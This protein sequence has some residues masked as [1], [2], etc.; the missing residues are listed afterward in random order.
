[1]SKRM[2]VAAAFAASVLIAARC[3]RAEAPGWAM[4]L[5]GPV[6]GSAVIHGE[7]A[8]FGR[9]KFAAGPEAKGA[10]AKVTPVEGMTS[11]QLYKAE[12]KTPFAVFSVY[13]KFFAENGY[14]TV[15][16]CEAKAC[17]QGFKDAWYGLN[18]F[19]EDYGWNNSAPLTKGAPETQFYI[20]AKKANPAG[21]VYVSVYV[22]SGWWNYPVY[23]L[24][25]AKEAPLGAG[26][27]K[28]EKIAEAMKRE[29]RIAFYGI[30]FDSGSSAI[31]PES[32]PVLDQIAAFLKASPGEKFYVVGH[33]DDEGDLQANMKLS[34][35]RAQAVLKD[36]Q[37]RGV[38]A[39]AL[40][41]HGAGPLSPVASNATEEGRKLNRRV[42]I[43]RRL[44]AAAKAA[45][46][47]SA[48]QAAQQQMQA[49]QQQMQA[50]Q[51]Q[52][53]AAQ[54]Q[55]QAAQQQTQAAQAKP[56]PPKEE[57]LFPVPN[58]VGKNYIEAAAILAVQGFKVK[59]TGKLLGRVSAQS[60]AENRMVKKGETVTLTV[61]K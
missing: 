22:N 28:A 59:R 26:I 45:A 58:L 3:A 17:G 54:Q 27:V 40:S 1:M 29:G 41:A 8:E 11:S 10:I 13:K 38:A 6:E 43:V 57:A 37:G 34:D 32:G 18:P 52:V 46:S 15:Y 49:A 21:N 53:Q 30:L 33:T 48:A 50:A 35:D 61:G 23:R 14:E 5:A 47:S 20:A 9:Y 16:S 31:K 7:A 56:E 55:V 51:Q 12:G 2:F 19:A 36:L 25:V 4:Q 39:A 44:T 24:D 42:E 60:P